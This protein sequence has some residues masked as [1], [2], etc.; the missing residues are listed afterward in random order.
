MTIYVGDLVRISCTV[1]PGMFSD[2]RTVGILDIKENRYVYFFA[3][4][5]SLPDKTARGPSVHGKV[6][7]LDEDRALVRFSGND[8]CETCVIAL[9]D[10]KEI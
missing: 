10:I 9:K 8:G 6:L 7:E 5:R 1:D 2:E 3:S 4:L